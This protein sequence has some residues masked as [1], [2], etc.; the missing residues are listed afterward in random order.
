MN[1]NQ[2]TMHYYRRSDLS[3]GLYYRCFVAYRPIDEIKDIEEYQRVQLRAMFVLED[4][5]QWF[6]KQFNDAIA[7]KVEPFQL[8]NECVG[9]DSSLASPTIEAAVLAE[10]ERCT[11]VCDGLYKH[12]RKSSGYD[13]GWNDALDIAGQLVAQTLAIEQVLRSMK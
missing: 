2:P 8:G 7:Q 11:K 5:A 6:C 13:E 12:D 4:D 10:R 3:G 1:E 9:F